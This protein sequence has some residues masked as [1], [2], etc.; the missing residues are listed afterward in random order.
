MIASDLGVVS[1]TRRSLQVYGG[2]SWVRKPDPWGISRKFPYLFHK[3]L[4]P[5]YPGRV[6][7]LWIVVKYLTEN[8]T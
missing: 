6:T 4:H 8:L 7:N 2:N 3:G 5:N 1:A